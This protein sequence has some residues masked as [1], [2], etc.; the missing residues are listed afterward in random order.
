M[1]NRSFNM[2]KLHEG[3]RKSLVS[4]KVYIYGRFSECMKK[5]IAFGILMLISFSLFAVSAS[6][7]DER[8]GFFCSIG[9]FLSKLFSFTG[10][11]VEEVPENMTGPITVSIQV[12]KG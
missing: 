2:D 8:C 4:A 5:I 12:V 11:A 6:A 3:F 1:K 9:K 10:S 7:S